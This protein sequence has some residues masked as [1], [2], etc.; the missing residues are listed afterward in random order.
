[1][2]DGKTIVFDAAEYPQLEGL[3]EGDTIK[4]I[5]STDGRVVSVVDGQITVEL[6]EC[7]VETEGA[8]DKAYRAQRGEPMMTSDTDDADD[9][10]DY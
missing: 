3:Q 9:E 8:A 7:E 2:A 6:G 5:R 4:S 10:E 1:M